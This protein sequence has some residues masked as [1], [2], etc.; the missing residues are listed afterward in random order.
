M[1]LKIGDLAPN[2]SL[3]N[4]NAEKISSSNFKNRSVVLL[5]FPFAYSS[6]CTKEMCTMRDDLK[7]FEDLSAQ[8]LGISVDS[9]Y[10]LKTWAEKL[11]LNFLLL[12][13]FNKEV[14]AKYDSLYD[15]Y[16]PGKYDYKGVSKRSAFVIDK[17][18]IIKYIEICPTTGDQPDYEKIKKVL[19]KER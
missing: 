11:N 17:N 16:S 1:H 19:E 18:G 8:V 12:S 10:T 7:K 14:S 2:F 3:I 6:V 15:I 4:H 5:F 13:D 9:H